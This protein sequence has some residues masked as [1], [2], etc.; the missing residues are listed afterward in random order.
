MLHAPIADAVYAT[1]NRFSGAA[2]SVSVCFV[3]LLSLEGDHIAKLMK[4]MD[5]L[6][7]V[8][9]QCAHS[10]SAVAALKKTLDQLPF[11]PL[12]RSM[13]L[14]VN[15]ETFQDLRPALFRIRKFVS[16]L[17]FDE[18]HVYEE[19]AQFRPAFESIADLAVDFPASSIVAATATFTEAAETSFCTKLGSAREDWSFFSHHYQRTN[20]YY[21]VISERMILR[22]LA[23]LFGSDRFPMLIV[24]SSLAL[25]A[26]LC[27]HVADWAGGDVTVLSYASGHSDDHKAASEARF[28]AC[29]PGD[30]VVLVATNAFGMGVDISFI[31]SVIVWGV[32][33]T[34]Q[35]LIQAFGRAGRNTMFVPLAYCTLVTTPNTLRVAEKPVRAFLGC[36]KKDPAG[37]KKSKAGKVYALCDHCITWRKLPAD[38]KEPSADEPFSCNDIGKKC[39]TDSPL[40]ACVVK[41]LERYSLRQLSFAAPTNKVTENCR[42]CDYCVLPPF[43]MVPP[44][45]SSVVIVAPG[46]KFFGH[47]GQV[48]QVVDET[49]LVVNCG[50]ALRITVPFVT[51]QVLECSVEAVLA[52]DPPVPEHSNQ[53]KVL[54]EALKS[55]VASF[56]SHLPPSFLISTDSY[57]LL[58]TWRPCTVENLR[59]LRGVSVHPSIAQTIVDV[60]TAHQQNNMKQPKP[61]LKKKTKRVTAVA[62]GDEEE[63]ISI[64]RTRTGRTVKRPNKNM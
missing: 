19:W 37:S 56:P 36:T 39:S 8:E 12:D 31:L 59:L 5:L 9:V 10:K 4:S 27:A 43:P 6:A 41:M 61:T 62:N 45:G 1:M 51:V 60:I 64:V 16:H 50:G 58:K 11:R 53:P 7:Y 15:P 42:R 34:L 13:L 33:T 63:A 44:V 20:L 46:T 38:R 22:K 54:E 55:A 24:A 17:I 40:P 32:P 52:E 18:A 14:F 35:A 2:H 23:T 47:R 26:F 57:A 21:S 29:K 30:R 49:R 28:R 25:V 3:P 48:D